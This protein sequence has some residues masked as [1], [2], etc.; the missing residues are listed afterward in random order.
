MAHHPY[1]TSKRVVASG[2]LEFPALVV[3]L[4][5]V[6]GLLLV[7]EEDDLRRIVEV[8]ELRA[9]LPGVPIPVV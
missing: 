1:L 3:P 2:E 4:L 5:L 7:E 6:R 8:V 9:G